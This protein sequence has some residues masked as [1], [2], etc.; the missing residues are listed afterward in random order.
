MESMASGA[1]NNGEILPLT[2]KNSW[3]VGLKIRGF[4]P[5]NEGENEAT[6]LDLFSKI[7]LTESMASGAEKNREILPLTWKNSWKVGLKIR[8]IRWLWHGWKKNMD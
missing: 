4:W 1:E 3:K 2:W 5:E 7:G 6:V 8:E